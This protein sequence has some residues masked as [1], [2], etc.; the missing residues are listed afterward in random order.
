VVVMEV[1]KVVTLVTEE[2]LTTM[3]ILEIDSG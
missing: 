3:L 1:N 2:A